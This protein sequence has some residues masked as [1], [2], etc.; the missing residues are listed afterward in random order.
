VKRS[1]N[2]KKYLLLIGI[3]LLSLSFLPSEETTLSLSEC[4]RMAMQ[5]NISLSLQRLN[6]EISKSKLLSARGEYDLNFTLGSSYSETDSPTSSTSFTTTHSDDY[7]TGLTQKIPFGTTFELSNTLDN[8]T[9]NTKKF[10]D[11]YSSFWGASFTQP[12]LRNFGS[13]INLFNIQSAEIDISIQDSIYQNEIDQMVTDVANAFFELL[14]ARQ[15]LESKQISLKVAEQFESE[16]QARLEIGTMTKLDLSQAKSELSTRQEE[17]LRAE[18]EIR[19]R[20]NN[21][22]LIITDQFEEWLTKQI[23]PNPD[24]VFETTPPSLQKAFQNALTNRPDLLQ[25]KK[26]AEQKNLVLQYRKNQDW[27]Q[28]D[29]SGNYG[30]NGL[31]QTPASSLRDTGELNKEEWTIGLTLKIP[32]QNRVAIGAR[33]QAQL[34]QQQILLEI[35]QKEQSIMSEVDNAISQVLTNQKRVESS[36]N[37]RAYIE[38]TVEAE[39]EKF[40]QGSS[41]TFT[42]LR[43]RRDYSDAKNREIRAKIDLEKSLAELHR[44]QGLSLIYVQEA[45]KET[46]LSNP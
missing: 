1:N 18:R 42:V 32:L 8:S 28:L 33:Q 25:L 24:S 16:N 23:I 13:K 17:V 45:K 9:S 4:I 27:P 40:K 26:T 6:P 35:K 3:G 21:L 7:S 31:D 22:K 38:E 30:F 29:L 41:T 39:E 2:L 15:D 43:L 5:K 12:L 37:T 14:F 10:V 36:K 44:V 11:S 19:F 46:P 20:E 34:Q